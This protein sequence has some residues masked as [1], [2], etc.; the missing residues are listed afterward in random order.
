MTKEQA[1]EVLSMINKGKK[2]LPMEEVFKVIDMIDDAPVRTVEYPI[3]Y[4]TYPR[5]WWDGITYCNMT[6]TGGDKH[7]C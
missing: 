6:C 3:V 1:K 5:P 2:E 7:E 4:P